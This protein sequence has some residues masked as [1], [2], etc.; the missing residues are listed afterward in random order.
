MERNMT[1]KNQPIQPKL[2]RLIELVDVLKHELFERRATQEPDYRPLF[3]IRDATVEVTAIAKTDNIR[4]GDMSI[5]L[6]NIGAKASRSLGPTFKMALTLEPL[7][8]DSPE[9]IV[10]EDPVA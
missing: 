1:K 2:I 6:V 9:M 5:Y 4:Q 3:R 8:Q 10:G 7:I